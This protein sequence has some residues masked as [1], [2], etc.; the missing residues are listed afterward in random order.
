MIIVWQPTAHRPGIAALVGSEPLATWKDYLT[1][2]AARSRLAAISRRPSSNERF[3]FYG[4]T[5]TGTPQLATAGSGA[6]VAATSVARGRRGRLYVAHYFPARGQGPGRD[7]GGEHRRRVRPAHRR[8]R[9]DDAGDQGEGEGEARARSTSGIGYPDHWRDYAALKIVRG[10]RA[11]QPAARPS[12]S[13]T[14]AISPSSA[15]RSTSTEW[16]MTPQTV[17]A[18][19][20]PLQ[21]ALN[22]PAAILN[23][24]FFDAGGRSAV[25]L[26]RDRR[27]HRPRDQPQLRRPGQPVRRRRAAVQLVDAGRLRALRGGRRRGSS[28]STTPTSRSRT[29]T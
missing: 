17:N 11:R 18:V 12:C 5:L 4:T 13:S 3:A 23:P 16:C 7:D 20:L 22:F 25:Q 19:N 15:S 26:R 2:H 8:A 27:G 24:P 10:R 6:R 21:N 1:F 9:L 29:C 28:R 14:T